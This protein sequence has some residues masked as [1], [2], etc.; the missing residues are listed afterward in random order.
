MVVVGPLLGRRGALGF[1]I[2]MLLAFAAPHRLEAG[3][4]PEEVVETLVQHIVE[5]LESDELAREDAADR[6]AHTIS[7]DVDLDRLGR[8]TLGRHWR[9]ADEAQ[10]AEYL[11]LF[12]QLMLT[13][14][15]SHLGVY[16]GRELESGADLFT[17]EGSRSIGERDVIVDSVVRPPDRPPVRAAW[18]LRGDEGGDWVIIDLIVENVS[19]LISQRSEFAS[20]I[21]RAGIDGL[22]GEMRERVATTRS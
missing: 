9:S 2:A 11:E 10:Q 18:R 7:E 6:L 15:I 17:I 8:L 3:T 1:L 19:L 4:R 20:V 14:F 16:S 12:R 5:L 21:E 22:L 13:K